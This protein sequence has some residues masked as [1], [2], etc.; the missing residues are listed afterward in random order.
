M[1][2]WSRSYPLVIVVLLLS[3]IWAIPRVLAVEQTTNQPDRQDRAW[4]QLIREAGDLELPTGFLER[5]RPGFVTIRFE[6]LRRFAAEYHPAQHRMVLNRSLSLNAAGGV[7]RPLERLTHREL[8]TL[9]H[10]LFH[11]YLDFVV[12]ESDHLPDGGPSRRL[13]AAARRQQ[14]CRYRQVFITPVRQR[15]SLT[16]MRFLTEGESWEALNETYAVF[17]EWVIWSRLHLREKFPGAA[18]GDDP[19]LTATWLRLLQEADRTGRLVGFYEPADPEERA[20]TNK[21]YLAPSYRITPE[22]SALLLEAVLGAS[23]ELAS[24]AAATMR[25]PELPVPP[26]PGCE[27]EATD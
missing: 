6:D 24:R 1:F 13:L 23:P 14:A 26:L 8:A 20:I 7:L 12:S 3:M 15:P 21:R 11:A 9:Y 27:A 2:S 25:R 10:E 18:W 22:D 19:G 4:Q 5:I 17:V 16:E